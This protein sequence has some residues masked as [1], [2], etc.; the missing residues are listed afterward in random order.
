LYIKF[1]KRLNSLL[2]FAIGIKKEMSTKVCIITG[3]N[4]G[5]GYEVVKKLL[6][7]NYKVI[8]GNYFLI[9]I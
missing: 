9:L 2:F 3:G 5:I 6:D 4:S 7:Q 8:V 1:Y